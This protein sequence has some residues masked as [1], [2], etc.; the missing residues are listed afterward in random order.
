MAFQEYEAE[1][2]KT[3]E[4]LKYHTKQ[5]SSERTKLHSEKDV[6][7]DLVKRL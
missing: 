3:R 1:I 4:E 7:L 5:W 2:S 6:A